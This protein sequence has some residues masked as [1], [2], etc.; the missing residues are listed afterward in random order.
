MLRSPKYEASDGVGFNGQLH[1]K[2]IFKDATILLQCRSIVETG[3][4]C[5]DTTAFMAE[6]SNLPVFSCEANPIFQSLAISRLKE[7]GGI[8]F[9]LSDS[10]QF[11]KALFQST[12]F[13]PH[14][15]APVLFYLDAHWHHDLPLEDEIDIIC[16]SVHDFAILVDDFAVPGDPGYTYDNYGMG[17]SLDLTT[18]GSC[19]KRNDLSVFFPSLPSASES[20]GRRG[21]VLLSSRSQA[22]TIRRQKS[23]KEHSL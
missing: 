4:Y 21:C 15:Q 9:Y 14:K 19:F 11:L 3:T 20:G 6:N 7:I 18:F 23:V 17:K 10:R 8:H 12:E 5:G 2:L 22:E 13:A 16:R 1:R